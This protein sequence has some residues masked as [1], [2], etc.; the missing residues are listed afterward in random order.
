MFGEP[1]Q[2]WA[3]S[4]GCPISARAPSHNSK[5]SKR[6]LRSENRARSRARRMGLHLRSRRLQSGAVAEAHGGLPVKAPANCRLIG[7]WRIVEADLWDRA[8][9]DLCGP[10]TL[11][12][13][14]PGGEIAFGALEAG[15][16]VEYARDS[17]GFQWAGCEEGDEVALSR[18]R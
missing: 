4:C 11:T 13:T 1:L 15:L 7:R 5:P 8:H 17:I 3:K 10:A 14:A 16:E 2:F 9:L 12:I 18:R 6:S